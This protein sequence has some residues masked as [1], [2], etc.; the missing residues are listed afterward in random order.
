MTEFLDYMILLAV[1]GV[2][3]VK[4]GGTDKGDHVTLVKYFIGIFFKLTSNLNRLLKDKY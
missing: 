1:A 4:W 3:F 2:G